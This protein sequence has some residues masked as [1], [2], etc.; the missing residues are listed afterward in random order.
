MFTTMIIFYQYFYFKE[1]LLFYSIYFENKYSF[2]YLIKNF[3]FEKDFIDKIDFYILNHKQSHFRELLLQNTKYNLYDN[4]K[5]YIY[6]LC[7]NGHYP[8]EESKFWNI[9]FSDKKCF[10]SFIWNHF[11]FNKKLD[12]IERMSKNYKFSKKELV[13][14]TKITSLN[15]DDIVFWFLNNNQLKIDKTSLFFLNFLGINSLINEKISI[16]NDFTLSKE[17]ITKKENLHFLISCLIQYK[18]TKLIN[19]IQK[20]YWKTSDF[21][22][23][24]KNEI[25][26][27]TSVFCPVALEDNKELQKDFF[28]NDFKGYSIK[29]LKTNQKE[30]LNYIE[31]LE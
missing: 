21:I 1:Q 20:K 10:D 11:L 26:N 4:K 23:I 24:I 31:S 29:Y 22:K 19:I 2:E 6:Y 3:E 27:K 18:N 5:Y 9:E 17:I 7:S 8:K 30:M 25:K 16:F 14:Y 15:N 12:K 28:N 13:Y